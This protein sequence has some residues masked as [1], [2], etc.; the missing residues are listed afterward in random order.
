MEDEYRQ[1]GV[2]ED[3]E[4]NEP[5][6]A[7]KQ[8]PTME[9]YLTLRRAHPDAEI[10]ISASNGL[11][12]L[13]RIEPELQK[14]GFD[15]SDIAGIL[16]ADPEAIS[17]VALQC[18]E[19]L[20]A[21]KQL[22]A[23]GETHLVGR[24]KAVPPALVDWIIIV[25]LDGMSWTQ[26]LEIPRDL[27]VL[28]QNRLGGIHGRYYRNSELNERKKTALIIAGQMLAR[29]E[30]PGIRRLARLLGLEAS[31][32]SR[33]FAEGE[34]DRESQRYASWFDENG[35]LSPPLHRK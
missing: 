3:G 23:K 24:G 35:N 8:D 6:L 13:F 7:Y 29:G 11:D 4:F 16:D 26:Q 9:T 15:P 34:F 10:E 28:I 19:K 14:H 32:V 20:V 2:N 1:W 33:W 22:A 5:T 30:K 18:M 21:A 12:T 31:S 27:I 25:A 17:K